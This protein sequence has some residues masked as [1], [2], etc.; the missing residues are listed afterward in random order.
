LQQFADFLVVVDEENGFTDYAHGGLLVVMAKLKS[1]VALEAPFA[2]KPA[3]TLE[4]VHT[5][6]CGSGLAREEAIAAY[7]KACSSATPAPVNPE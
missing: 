2:G 5:S 7:A 3:P 6:E 1:F 4:G